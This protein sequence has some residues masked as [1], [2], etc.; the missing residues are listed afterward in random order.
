MIECPVLLACE[1]KKMHMFIPAPVFTDV[2]VG[3]DQQ[4]LIS[5]YFA[6][7]ERSYQVKLTEIHV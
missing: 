4:V 7:K 3:V 1:T 6:M 5:V 2:K